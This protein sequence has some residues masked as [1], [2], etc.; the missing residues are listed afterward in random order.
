MPGSVR[1][2]LSYPRR[3]KANIFMGCFMRNFSKNRSGAP[4]RLKQRVEC[5][6]T[7]LPGNF[8][9]QNLS[10]LDSFM[11]EWIWRNKD[12]LEKRGIVLDL[13]SF[14]NTLQFLNSTLV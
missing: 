2:N 10:P 9:V 11:V 4:G 12:S 3:G 5:E 8:Y 7:L 14:A 6:R 1:T 13:N